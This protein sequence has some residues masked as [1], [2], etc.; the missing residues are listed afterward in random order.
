M[1]LKMEFALAALISFHFHSCVQSRLR[2][3][4]MGINIYPSSSL[5]GSIKGQVYALT[6]PLQLSSLLMVLLEWHRI[7]IVELQARIHTC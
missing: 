1:P 3:H 6:N 4:R 7:L 2:W 5:L